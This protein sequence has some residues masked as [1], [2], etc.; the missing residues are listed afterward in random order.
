M[1]KLSLL[2]FKLSN[3]RISFSLSFLKW[4]I[5]PW[6]QGDEPTADNAQIPSEAL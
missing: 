4:Q 5:E 3:L 1:G 2:R 6:H